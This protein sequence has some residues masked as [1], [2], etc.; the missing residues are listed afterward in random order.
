VDR[1]QAA[2]AGGCTGMTPASACELQNVRGCGLNRLQGAGGCGRRKRRAPGVCVA[3]LCGPAGIGRPREAA[4]PVQ[5]N[6]RITYDRC[7]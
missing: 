3:S 6:E 5:C 2:A 7:F 1:G 4:M